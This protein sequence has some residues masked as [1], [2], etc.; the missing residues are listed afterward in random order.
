M[1]VSDVSWS[2]SIWV[3]AVSPAERATLANLYQLYIHDFS[4]FVDL[5]VGD[6]GRFDYDPLPAY[7]TEPNHFA[8]LIRADSRLVGFALVKKGSSFFGDADVWDMA[9]FFVV[10]GARRRGLGSAIAEIV[11]RQFPGRWEV[12]VMPTN[13]P[14]LGFWIKAVSR[15]TG[16]TATPEI[17][18][19][20]DETRYLFHLFSGTR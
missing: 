1:A 13:L 17:A 14:A 9:D 5:P 18:C 4:D 2:R 10:R 12:R 8:L 16:E 15:F 19:R 6:N 20:G 7:W 11:W 3:T